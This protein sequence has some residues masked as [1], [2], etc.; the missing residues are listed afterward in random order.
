VTTLHDPAPAQTRPEPDVEAYALEAV[1]RS[2]VHIGAHTSPR[3]Q[4]K[5]VGASEVGHPC[6]RRL[7]YQLV[8]T[9][10]VNLGDPLRALVGTGTHLALAELMHRM[11]AGTGRWL[12]ETPVAYRGVPGT[13]DLYDR[14][15]GT[16]IDWKTTLRTKVAR[17][18]VDG[19]P[20]QY[21]T[22]LQIYAAALEAVGET[23]RWTAL[24]YLPIDSG[25]NDLW[26]WRTGYHRDIADAA[27][28]RL[29]HL[30][31]AELET[32]AGHIDPATVEAV[33]NYLCAWCPYHQPGA[34]DLSIACPGN[35]ERT[36]L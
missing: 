1:L 33:P 31:R 17:L 19:P 30:A 27:V 4:Q 2:L 28:D 11:D 5:T 29:Q 35:T 18:R 21:V 3:S 25:L 9:T 20:A 6:P 10:P 23:P 12:V 26:V 13:V 16:V 7:A 15:T 22:Q 8:H 14:M 32:T 36:P 24:A 34:V